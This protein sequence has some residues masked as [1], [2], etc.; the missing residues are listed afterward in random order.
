M[1]E[2][3]MSEEELQEYYRKT[4]FEISSKIDDSKLLKRISKLAEYLYIY[5]Q[6]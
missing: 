1:E 6:E 2:N 3:K 4:I 5:K